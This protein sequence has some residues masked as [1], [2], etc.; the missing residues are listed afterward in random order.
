MLST[1]AAAHSE[2]EI[3][4]RCDIGPK[5][6]ERSENKRRNLWLIINT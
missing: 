2:H 6:V 4:I 3:L 1:D 5:P